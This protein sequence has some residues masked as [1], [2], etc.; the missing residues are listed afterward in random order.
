[1]LK[2]VMKIAFFSQYIVGHRIIANL[3]ITFKSKKRAKKEFLG[4]ISH[5]VTPV[6]LV[7]LISQL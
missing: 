7:I 4:G 6:I 1:M 5:S 3:S 2:F